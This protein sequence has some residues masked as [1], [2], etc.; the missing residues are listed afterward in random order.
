M[1]SSQCIP[2]RRS[3]PPN[4]P[5]ETSKRREP[6]RHF[7]AT[8][9]KPGENNSQGRVL[10][11]ALWFHPDHKGAASPKPSSAPYA[12]RGQVG[13]GTG[14]PSQRGPCDPEALVPVGPPAGKRC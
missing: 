3:G 9:A 11:R 14:G 4:S 7:I 13:T 6:T 8:P 1:P 2:C 10:V 12:R 5:P